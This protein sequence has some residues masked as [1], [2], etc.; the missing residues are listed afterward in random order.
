MV[1]TPPSRPRRQYAGLV[2]EG[3]QFRHKVLW[4]NW[5]GSAVRRQDRVD[6]NIAD[7]A[8]LSGEFWNVESGVAVGHKHEVPVGRQCR[9]EPLQHAAR[10]AGRLRGAGLLQHRPTAR[11]QHL[12][13]WSPSLRAQKRTR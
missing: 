9:E 5:Y 1:A 10:L 3:F 7:D 6:E 11:A 12:S 4:C 8:P 2:G 13:D